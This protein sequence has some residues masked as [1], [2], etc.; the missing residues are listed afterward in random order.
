MTIKWKREIPRS[1]WSNDKY[2]PSNSDSLQA[3]LWT[4]MIPIVKLD[5][6]TMYFLGLLESQ[7]D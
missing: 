5:E 1:S 7:M 3:S 6:T 4:V 2:D